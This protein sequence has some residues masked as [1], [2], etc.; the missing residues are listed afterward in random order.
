MIKIWRYCII[1][2][3]ST[4]RQHNTTHNSIVKTVMHEQLN[5]FHIYSRVIKSSQYIKQSKFDLNLKIVYLK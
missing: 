1:L 2:Q 4:L 3:E 5:S